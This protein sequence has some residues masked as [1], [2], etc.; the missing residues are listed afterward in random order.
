M[1]PGVV[2]RS[3][4]PST[5]EAEADGSEFKISLPYIVQ[6]SQGCIVR[7]SFK[8]KIKYHGATIK[9]MG[10]LELQC[11]KDGVLTVT[12]QKY[13]HGMNTG[14]IPLSQSAPGARFIKV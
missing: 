11:Y 6:S 4:N 3:F 12:I 10:L 9:N 1:M 14:I 5:Q 2:V 13:F 7:S 8:K